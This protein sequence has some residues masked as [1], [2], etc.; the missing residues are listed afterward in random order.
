ME[1]STHGFGGWEREGDGEGEFG[2]EEGRKAGGGIMMVF[3][4][5]K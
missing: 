5:L 1:V 4:F 3:P 2:I